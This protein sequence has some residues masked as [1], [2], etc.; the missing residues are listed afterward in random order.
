M[1]ALLLNSGR[2]SRMGD[3]T[4]EH[5]KCMTRIS[6]T[7]TIISWQVRLLRACGVTE[8]VVTTGPFAELLRD[9]LES[10]DSGIRFRY[11]ANPLYAETNY[12]YSM[13][14]ARALLRDDVLLLHGDLVLHPALMQALVSSDVSRC[15]TDRTLPLPEKD[16]KAR[17]ENGRIRAIGIDRFGPDCE[18]SQPAYHFL[19]ADFERWMAEIVRFVER[20]ERGCYAENAFNAASAEIPLYPLEAEGR[21]CS[22]IDTPEDL[23]R[24]SAAYAT[25]LREMN[26]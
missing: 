26:L 24:V 12:I 8:A 14:L 18:A 22:E 13:Y 21:L 4:R 23:Q 7:E 11:V 25:M 15:V 1:I 3:E 9:H 2:G 20:G 19:R 6:D 10:L 17:L 5:P 16:F